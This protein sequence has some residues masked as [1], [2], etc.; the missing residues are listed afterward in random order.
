MVSRKVVDFNEGREFRENCGF[1][2]FIL[3]LDRRIVGFVGSY[4]IGCKV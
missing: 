2:H 3:S 4:N 1:L